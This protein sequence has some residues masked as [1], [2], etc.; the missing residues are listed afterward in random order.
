M[1]MVNK[2]I[3]LVTYIEELPSTESKDSS[4]LARSSDK[5]NKLYHYY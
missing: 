5:L 1:Y 3:R 4:G 2:P